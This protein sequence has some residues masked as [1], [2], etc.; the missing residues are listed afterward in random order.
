[1]PQRLTADVSAV[2]QD[3]H[4]TRDSTAYHRSTD[5]RP[6]SDD[7][8]SGGRQGWPAILSSLKSVLETGNPLS[9]QMAPPQRML[10]ALKEL[11]IGTP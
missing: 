2:H 4:A 11:G 1:M 3:A 10:D 8:L 5:D 6:I 7:I 9:V